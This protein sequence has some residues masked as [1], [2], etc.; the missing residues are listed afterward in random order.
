MIG[1][2]V[3]ERY[4]V[5]ALLGEGGMG[6][7]YRAVD[8]RGQAVAIKRLHAEVATSGDLV[9][10]FQREASAHAILSHPNIAAMHAV[11]VTDAG[12]LFF[13]LELIEGHDLATELERGALAPAR[14][15]KLAI[16]LLSGLHHAHQF[17]MVHR[18]LKPENVLLAGS[19]DHEQAK[20]IDFGLVKL[21]TDVL[22]SD[23]CQRLTRT[24][25]V[26]G[27]PQY[28][29]PEQMVPEPVDPID[30]RSDLYAVGILLFEMLCGRRPFE[31]DEI[32]QLWRAH[33]T[34]PAP[35]LAEFEPRLDH[36]DLDAILQT[37]LAKRPSQRFASALAVRRALES[38]SM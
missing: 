3:L 13:V 37:L 15:V 1:E 35:S 29:A 7:V 8:E 4:T 21:L 20:L 12:H 14:A 38:L 19:G 30:H 2:T 5:Q 27:T 9:A 25:V 17:G 34:E 10:R 36:P 11:G 22:G 26:F 23:E 31:A 16:Q 6:E 32:T 24:G 33:L 28:M 18:D